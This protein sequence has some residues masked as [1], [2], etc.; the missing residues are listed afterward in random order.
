M[1]TSISPESSIYD[2]KSLN[3]AVVS[4]DGTSIV[5]VVGQVDRKTGFNVGHLWRCD[6]DGGNQR[7]ITQSGASNGDPVWSPDGSSIAYVSLRDGDHP[8][9]I[10]VLPLSGGESRIVTRHVAT[11]SSLA[12]SPDGRSI[13]YAVE[14][15]PDNLEE[16]P[17]DKNA[18]PAVIVV[19][20]LDYKLDGRGAYN[21]TRRQ[22]H[23]VDVES[24][25]RR[26][27]TGPD[28]HHGRPIWSPDGKTI[29]AIADVAD[30]PD[31]GLVLIDVVSG[32]I[33]STDMVGSNNGG[34]WTPDGTSILYLGDPDRTSS[35]D[36]Y[37][38]NAADGSTRPVTTDVHFL[39]DIGY[40]NSAPP[41]NP[42]WL[43][44]TTAIVHGL[45][46]GTSGLWELDIETGETQELVRWL[47][48]HGGLSATPDQ[49]KIVQSRST[50]EG[51]GELIIWDRNSGETEVIAAPNG[52]YFA[53]SPTASWERVHL[54]RAGFEIDGW[55]LKP[56]DFDP[57]K[58][59]PLV[60]S[61]HGGP[62]NAY[63]YQ[64][65]VS[66][67][68]LASNGYLVLMTNPRGSGTY[69]R[70][71]ASAV[72]GDWGGEDWNDLNA[73]LDLVVDR[74]YVDADRLGV[75]GYSYGGYITAWAVGNSNRFKAIVCG[76]P[77]YDMTSM[78]GTSDIGFFFTP[79][80]LQADPVKDRDKLIERS[81]STWAH[82]ATT[83]T[84]IIQGEADDRCPV[85]QAEQMFVDLKL[86]GCKTQL[87]RYPGGSHLML[88]RSHA[89]HRIDYLTRVLGWFD[90]HLTCT[91]S[92]S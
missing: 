2:I 73:M 40:Q 35:P 76:A 84:L 83:P 87:I 75:Y 38:L 19:D 71:F 77:V 90:E 1:T 32:A 8:G 52:A 11:P 5:Y 10:A 64:F 4:P 66:A 62:H 26:R 61:V 45:S 24:G 80:Q 28:V 23:V 56:N 7:Q 74:P 3:S 37:V 36:Y 88:Y 60:L 91:N 82:R 72:H 65:D 51:T 85:G 14:V 44:N 86:A 59:Y 58:S 81:P 21:T 9:A 63:G 42:I 43:S 29:A 33:R 55:L 12:W 15:D 18:A 46:A 22:V 20:R 54:E 89:D 78:Y 31:S 50:M 16:K 68:V 17:K 34:W 49:A 53:T 57:N 70:A 6:I 69:G 79:N 30:S 48:M 92:E 13:A 39:P 25:E 47:A 41:G 67:Q 27:L